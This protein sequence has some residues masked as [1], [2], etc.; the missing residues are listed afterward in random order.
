MD[1][2]FLGRVMKIEIEA[3]RVVDTKKEH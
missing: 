1:S 3:Q 2:F